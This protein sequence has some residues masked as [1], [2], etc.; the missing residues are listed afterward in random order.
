MYLMVWFRFKQGA[1]RKLLNSG[2]NKEELP[3]QWK[4]S[5]TLPVHKKGDEPVI[6][7]WYI[8]VIT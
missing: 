1:I 6:V 4:E 8:T 2:W 3:D 7:M 5:T